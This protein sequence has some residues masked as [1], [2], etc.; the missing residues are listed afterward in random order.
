[1]HVQHW[2]C[3]NFQRLNRCSNLQNPKENTLFRGLSILMLEFNPG[4]AFLK[5][6]TTFALSIILHSIALLVVDVSYP[7]TAPVLPLLIRNYCVTSGHPPKAYF[8]CQKSV[9]TSVYHCPLIQTLYN[10]SM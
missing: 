6:R 2:F 9:I 3:Q 5:N 7:P 10:T 8:N 1:M 4:I